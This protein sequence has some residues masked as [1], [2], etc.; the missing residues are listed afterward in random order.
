[1]HVY[2]PII[3]NLDYDSVRGFCETICRFV[4][5]AHPK[6]TTMEWGTAQRTGK[7]FLDHNMNARSKTIASVYS[8]RAS[9]EAGVSMPV[10]WSGLSH[11]FPSDFHLLNAAERVR[12]KGDLWTD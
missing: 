4:H 9:L 3:R 10:E 7:V 6:D 1:L 12:S 5:R 8:P 11:V 2:V